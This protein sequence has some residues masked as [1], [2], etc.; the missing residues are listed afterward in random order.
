MW[1]ER[2]CRRRG[3]T[4]EQRSSGEAENPTLL[5][6]LESYHFPIKK[7][8]GVP[9]QGPLFMSVAWLYNWWS[10]RRARNGAATASR[11]QPVH[12]TVCG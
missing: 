12:K 11:D 8:K 10:W 5:E 4:G 9:S 2:Q 1:R 3:A 6:R 7:K